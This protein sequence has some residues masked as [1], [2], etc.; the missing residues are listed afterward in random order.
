M[1]EGKGLSCEAELRRIDDVSIERTWSIVR[2]INE[3]EGMDERHCVGGGAG[4]RY[5]GVVKVRWI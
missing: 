1:L 4:E 2:L 3:G 5:S